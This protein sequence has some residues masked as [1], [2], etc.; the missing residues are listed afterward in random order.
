MFKSVL[1]TEAALKS[2]KSNRCFQSMYHEV[3][4]DQREVTYTV[5][6]ITLGKQEFLS[7]AYR[8]NLPRLVEI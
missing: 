7:V 4:G 5:V 8:K 2:V 6:S 1:V 3:Y